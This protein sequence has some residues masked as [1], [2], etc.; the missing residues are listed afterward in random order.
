MTFTFGNVA[1]LAMAA[2]LA[3]GSA[4]AA[5]LFLD[6]FESGISVDVPGWTSAKR[7]VSDVGIGNDN[8]NLAL[9]LRGELDPAGL[10]AAAATG[11][12]D[13]G[14]Y[15]DITVSFRWRAFSLNTAVAP[16]LNLGWA[17]GTVG[18]ITDLSSW[19]SVF[20]GSDDGYGWHDATVSLGAL[21]DAS[22][23]SLMFWT[24]A[25]RTNA[26]DGFWIDDVSV[27]GTP[28]PVP[29]P[30]ALP[31]LAVALGAFALVRRRRG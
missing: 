7:L 5:P 9:R 20:T 31:L 2:T 27:S 16:Y 24:S 19:T 25:G 11:P 8:Q 23:L 13:V 18:D 12:I 10:N 22:Q 15:S 21:A 6:D 3:A 29:L 28:S 1:A 26:N 17:L 14:G 30:A 4:G